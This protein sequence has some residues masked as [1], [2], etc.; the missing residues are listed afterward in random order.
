L[1]PTE[2]YPNLEGGVLFGALV[3]LVFAFLV[4]AGRQYTILWMGVGMVAGLSVQV[5]RE[6]HR[7]R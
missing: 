2:K 5:Y 1:K 6:I 4:E 7:T 3:G